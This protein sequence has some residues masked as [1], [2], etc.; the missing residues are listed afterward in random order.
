MKP[1]LADALILALAERAIR[2]R[3]HLRA[4]RAAGL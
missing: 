1:D 4:L 3:E 2:H